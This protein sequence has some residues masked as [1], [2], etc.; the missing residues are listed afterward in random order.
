MHFRSRFKREKKELAGIDCESF[1]SVL[2]ELLLQKIT[3]G[4]VLKAPLLYVWDFTQ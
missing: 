3:C 2:A 4:A 1:I